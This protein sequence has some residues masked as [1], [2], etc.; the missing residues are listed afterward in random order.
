[1][2]GTEAADSQRWG[3]GATTYL[4]GRSGQFSQQEEES[5]ACRASGGQRQETLEPGEGDGLPGVALRFQWKQGLEENSERGGKAGG[6]EDSGR[7]NR[8]KG[9]IKKAE[10]KKE[11]PNLIEP[12]Y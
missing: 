6:Q 9:L 5:C 7:E 8:K 11:A 3:R 10:E 12:D 4:A 1:M 2:W